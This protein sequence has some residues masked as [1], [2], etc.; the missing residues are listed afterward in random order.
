MYKLELVKKRLTIAIAQSCWAVC[1]FYI[2]KNKRKITAYVLYE[3]L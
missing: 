1:T 2:F 3:E